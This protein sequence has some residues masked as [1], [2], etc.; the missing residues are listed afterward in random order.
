MNCLKQKVLTA[1]ILL[2]LAVSIVPTVFA[3]N[4]NQ[5]AIDDGITYLRSQQDANG[6]I[7]GF[8]GITAWAAQ[9]FASAG[10]DPATVKNGGFSLLDYLSSSPPATS[11][12]A[13]DWERA[14]LAITASGV[15]PYNFGGIDYVANLE[16][17]HNNAQ[18]GS[19][20]LLNDDVFGL[21]ALIS[22]DHDA[23]SDIKQ[24]ALDFILSHQNT[25]GGFSWSTTGSSDTDDTAAALQSL[26]AAQNTGMSA[27]NLS[28]AITNAKNY[29][30]SAKNSDGGFPYLKGDLSNTSTS[31]WVVMT[32]SSLGLDETIESTN[33]KSYIR[34]NQEQNG[35]FKWQPS[36]TGE[37]FTTSYAILALTGKFWPLLT[38]SP[39]VTPS[40]TPTP[41]PTSTPTSTPTPTP[42]N[43]PTS[44]P[45]PTNI[46]THTPTPT[47]VPTNTV[48]PTPKAYR[49]SQ[50]FEESLETVRREIRKNIDML[51]EEMK[52]QQEKIRSIWKMNFQLFH[53]TKL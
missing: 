19:A 22:A 37:T 14:I 46:P 48:T 2:I 30:L 17:Y 38:P 40:T 1:F 4:L 11:S 49:R 6:Q 41:T 47:V 39:T 29:I 53:Q 10:V 9:A 50:E 26:V 21:L 16:T 34:E 36:T 42:T 25:D 45:S 15:N 5:Q 35:S 7:F 8:P 12:P 31:S 32:L 33:A 18:I 28:S 13:T 27:P 20:T 44:T 23:P 43:I 52:K 3:Q 51:R 24:D